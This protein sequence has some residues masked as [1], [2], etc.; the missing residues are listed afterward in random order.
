MGRKPLHQKVMEDER[1][2]R[3]ESDELMANHGA[4]MT[5][6]LVTVEEIGKGAGKGTGKGFLVAFDG[7]KFELG[8]GVSEELLYR[9]TKALRPYSGYSIFDNI[10]LEVDAV[11][12]RLMAGEEDEDGLDKGRAEAFTMCLAMIRNP[13]TPNYDEEKARLMTRYWKLQNGEGP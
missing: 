9:L 5:D 2:L 8:Q 3:Q 1:R 4:G 10:L 13:Y 11:L 7:M 6:N 12:E